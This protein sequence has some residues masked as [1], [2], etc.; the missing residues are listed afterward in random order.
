MVCPFCQLQETSVVDSRKNSEG[1]SI[2]RRR[3]CSAC[4]LRFTTYEKA[5]IGIIV[6]KRNGNR[7]EFNLEK[8]YQG[9]QNA[10]GG[11]ELSEKKLKALVEAIHNDIKEQGNKVQSEFIGETVLK[12]LKDINEVAYVRFASVYKEFS[13]ASDFEKEAAEFN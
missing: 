3:N 1:T 5:S 7:E 11:Q 8:L 2:R 10:F 9:V 12:H 13:D 6:K 4:N